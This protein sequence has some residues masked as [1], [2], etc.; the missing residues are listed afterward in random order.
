MIF[1]SNYF[2]FSASAGIAVLS[3]KLVQ[4]LVLFFLIIDTFYF[5]V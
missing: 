3:I 2:L 5:S 1:L 4:I